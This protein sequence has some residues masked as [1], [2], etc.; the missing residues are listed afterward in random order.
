MS[1]PYETVDAIY[2][3]PYGNIAVRRPGEPKTCPVCAETGKRSHVRGT[4]EF[5][6]ATGFTTPDGAEHTGSTDV[7]WETLETM[8]AEVGGD[9]LP[10]LQC[11]VGHLFV[12]P[13]ITP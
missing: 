6:E 10:V 11:S 1:H 5:I 3:R 7:E 8:T 4:V 13:G 9:F 2:S 12:H